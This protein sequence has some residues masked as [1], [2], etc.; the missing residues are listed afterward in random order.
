VDESE[1]YTEIRRN[2]GGVRTT[3]AK[4]GPTNRCG[5]GEKKK[6]ERMRGAFSF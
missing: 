5:E 2:P 3:A 6:E 4:T 1:A